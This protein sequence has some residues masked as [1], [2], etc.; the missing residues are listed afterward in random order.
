M[1]QAKV[2]IQLDSD[3]L[4]STFDAI[5]AVDSGV[6][7]LLSYGDV[8]PENLT[9]LVHGAM[10]TRAPDALKNT[11]IFIGGSDAQA[12]ESIAAAVRKLFFG[13]ISVSVMLDGNGSN[14]TAVAAVLSAARHVSLSDSKA[15]VLGGTGPVGGRV[16]RLLLQQGTAVTLVSRDLT[17]VESARRKILAHLGPD[18]ETRLLAVASSDRQGLDR[19]IAA[20]DAIF[21]CGAAGVQLLDERQ[22]QL[23]DR[24]RVAID[25]NAVPP[26]GLFGI[27]ATDK[28]EKRGERFDYGAIGV[29]GLK[30][31]IHRASIQKL[32]TKNDLLLDAEE[33]MQ[34][35][36]QLEN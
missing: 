11:A 5:V 35:G 26:C 27:A 28:A 33:I 19:E 8:S 15:L 2:L 9:P 16:A 36:C 29:G 12:G 32:F 4:P 22:M 34:V 1:S 6:E 7:H 21:G 23:A 17:R 20:T 18:F 14:T 24:A 13:P 31:K 10:F 3:P 25:L 30:M